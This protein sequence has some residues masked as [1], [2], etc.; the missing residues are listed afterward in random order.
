MARF[1]RVVKATDLSEKEE[2]IGCAKGNLGLTVAHSRSIV[3]T[4]KKDT[5]Q[6]KC[7]MRSVHAVSLPYA[8]IL[9]A[10]F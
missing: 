5:G 8:R 3:R 10:K 9:G 7:R 4:P 6:L 1:R 2:G